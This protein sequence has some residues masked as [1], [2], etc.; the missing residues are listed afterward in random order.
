MSMDIWSKVSEIS[1]TSNLEFFLSG[2]K[3]PDGVVQ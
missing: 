2:T 3:I 1:G